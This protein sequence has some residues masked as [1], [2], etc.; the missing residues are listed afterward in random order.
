MKNPS[1]PVYEMDTSSE[2]QHR[3]EKIVKIV[4]CL[5][6][7]QECYKKDQDARVGDSLDE[8]RSF[9]VFPLRVSQARESCI[10]LVSA[11]RAIVSL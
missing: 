9:M 6:A 3:D 2:D 7:L 1:S 8:E 5:A 4:A 11:W 10:A